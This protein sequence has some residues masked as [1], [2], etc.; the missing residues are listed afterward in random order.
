MRVSEPG[1][2][3]EQEMIAMAQVRGLGD[4]LKLMREGWQQ[5]GGERRRV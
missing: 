5:E 3:S 4:G 1:H 2:V